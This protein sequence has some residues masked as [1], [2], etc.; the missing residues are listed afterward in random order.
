[1]HSTLSNVAVRRTSRYAAG[2]GPL[3]K[4]R[5]TVQAVVSRSRGFSSLDAISRVGVVGAGQMGVGIAIVSTQIAGRDV[6]LFDISGEQLEKALKFAEKLMQRNVDKGKLTAEEK[7]I[8]LGRIS[9]T[10]QLADLSTSDFIIEAA[11]ENVDLKLK[12]FSDLDELAKP[13]AILATNTSSISITK[14]AAAT[15]RPEAVI[16]MHFMNPVPVMKLVEIIDGLATSKETTVTTR[17][18]AAAMGKTTAV[19][20]DVPG[21]IANRLL[22]PYLNEAVFALSEGIGSAEDIDT[23]MKLGTNVPMGPLQLA[24]FIGLDTCLAI[25]KVLHEGLG[26]DKYRPSPLLQKYVDAGWLGKKTG[27]GFYEY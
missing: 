16:G 24:D 3:R 26:E 2:T 20:Q 15:D 25:S 9:L 21:F 17:E 4:A 1:M 13:D 11:T 23:V 5:R 19:A 6:T 7:D 14:I 8:A 27:R 22:I 12:L 18:L 10:D